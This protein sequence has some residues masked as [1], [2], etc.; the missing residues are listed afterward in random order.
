MNATRGRRTTGTDPLLPEPMR[1][2]RSGV[3]SWPARPSTSPRRMALPTGR[4][5]APGFDGAASMTTCCSSA[6]T[7]AC[8]MT[9]AVS[10]PSGMATPVLANSQ[11]RPRTH[12]L[13]SGTSPSARSAKSDQCSA[14][15][16]MAQVSALGISFT[17]RTSYAST[18]PTDSARETRSTSLRSTFAAWSA[19]AA[20]PRQP[21]PSGCAS[22]AANVAATASS[23]DSCICCEWSLM[24][25]SFP[26]ARRKS[27]AQRVRN[28][29]PSPR[30][31]A[32]R[33]RAARS[34][35]EPAFGK[36]FSVEY[37]SNYSPNSC[38]CVPFICFCN[39]TPTAL[40][41]PLGRGVYSPL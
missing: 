40:A 12:A 11:S 17:A 41:P 7:C 26:D 21:K 19:D 5:P 9:M 16:S 18:R 2:A 4:V 34:R 31:A 25:A 28:P 32:K 3:I 33:T 13:V 27:G 36:L 30:M 20:H 39:R 14:M 8:S 35:R 10:N 6:E 15:E 24:G 1:A 23:R 37:N 38:F 29:P 22:S